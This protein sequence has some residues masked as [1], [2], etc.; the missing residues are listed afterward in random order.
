MPSSCAHS[1]CVRMRRMVAAT[2][3]S[4][5]AGAYGGRRSGEMRL[6]VDLR[7][8][9]GEVDALKAQ[10]AVPTDLLRFLW[11]V[12][13]SPA[14]QELR[15]YAGRVNDHDLAHAGDGGVRPYIVPG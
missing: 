11:P 1:A 5:L 6:R 2:S 12:A 10:G 9:A 4:S 8:P 13:V 14:P 15:Q 7:Q 3:R